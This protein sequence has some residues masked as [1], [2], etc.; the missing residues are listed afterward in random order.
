[1][2]DRDDGRL[3]DTVAHHPVQFA[4]T[5]CVQLCLEDSVVT[6]KGDEVRRW[7]GGAQL[8]T[9][10]GS[11]DTAQEALLLVDAAGYSLWCGDATR[12]SLREVA[13]GYGF[14]TKITAS[15]DPVDTTR[16]HLRVSRTG[17]VSVLGSM[18]IERE[19]GTCIGRL[20]AGLRSADC[21][22]QRTEL[23]AYL[24]RHAHLEAA[25]VVS[26]ERLARELA[27][28]GAPHELVALSL[29]ARADEVRHAH[30]IGS[31]AARRGA[32]LTAPEV[33]EIPIRELFAIAL[34]NAVEGCV[35][36]TFGA[37]LGGYQA[38]HAEDSE[39]RACMR[40][41]AADEA[42]HAALAQ[43][44]HRFLLTRLSPSP[45]AR[46]SC[47]AWSARSSSW[48]RRSRFPWKRR[49]DERS[50]CLRRTSHDACS[51]R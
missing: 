33:A 19:F 20:P 18:V 39:L 14:A 25:S 29:E 17:D 50:A 45:G 11:I 2:R 4:P 9:L 22:G 1:M 42:R 49:C 12:T 16:Y 36:E 15:C 21:E 32:A 35:R 10:L 8:A 40:R 41:I 43:R 24:A 13:D 6:T 31:L 48:P 38:E 3:R 5:F 30:I 46:P 27:H 47:A 28:H 34:K 26:F 51:T 23:A 37:L 7:V 44:A